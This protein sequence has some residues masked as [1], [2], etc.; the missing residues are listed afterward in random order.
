MISKKFWIFVDYSLLGMAIVSAAEILIKGIF[1][2]QISKN[3]GSLSFVIV[4]ALLNWFLMR[5]RN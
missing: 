2:H 1:Y 5:K 4:F 3:I